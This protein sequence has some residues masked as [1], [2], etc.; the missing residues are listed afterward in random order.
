[1]CF[2]ITY[3]GMCFIAS[4]ISVSDNLFMLLQI[5]QH[6]MVSRK[7]TGAV[8][9]SQTHEPAPEQDS[10]LS[11]LLPRPQFP[12]FFDAATLSLTQMKA[13]A[14]PMQSS[15]LEEVGG[16]RVWQNSI[17]LGVDTSPH[18]PPQLF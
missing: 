4:I 8:S 12:A 9:A 14:H 10:D 15:W 6:S 13:S 3:I 11:P 18:P 16:R 7:A 17:F 2:Y 1:M 5:F